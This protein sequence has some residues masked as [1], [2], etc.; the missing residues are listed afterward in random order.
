[1]KDS[2]TYEDLSPEEMQI[3]L[4]VAKVGLGSIDYQ[5][6]TLKLD[7]L[8]AG[9]FDLPAATDI[10][11]NQLHDR[12]HPEDRG[13]VDKL[14]TGLLDPAVENTFDAT[15]RVV[16]PDDGSTYWIRVR[17]KIWFKEDGATIE[18]EK[19]VF[20][21]V[22]IT[23]EKRAQALSE[24]LIGELSHRGRNVITVISGIARQLYRHSSVDDFYD[25][26]MTR[27]NALS[28]NMYTIDAQ[29][30]S[31]T[32]IRDV[33][34]QQIEPFADHSTRIILNGPSVMMTQ[35]A[36]QVLAMAAHELLTNA[37]KYGALSNARGR[38]FVDWDLDP[39]EDGDL[40][41][42]WTE[43]DGPPVA[44]PEHQGYGS[45]V[46]GTLARMSLQAEVET[47]YA[48]TGLITNFVIPKQQIM[49]A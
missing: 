39:E 15:H 29:G 7:Q 1:M 8:A 16:H 36:G 28:R 9:L 11:R 23:A 48:S 43:R 35:D 46:V 24:A 5:S 49:G 6:D 34:T 13:V 27:L 3:G 42:T 2:Q 44:P 45:Q 21:V 18:P 22:D 37:A 14:V 40:R 26:F 38:V 19:A 30:R 47:C 12:I 31:L 32:D 33:F 17:K 10:P 41:L 20:A 4:H 25:K